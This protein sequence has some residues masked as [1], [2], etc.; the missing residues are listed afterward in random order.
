MTLNPEHAANVEPETW[1]S[2]TAANRERQE[3]QYFIEYEAALTQ[4]LTV[5]SATVSLAPLYLE[6]VLNTQ[7][8]I[9]NV[10]KRQD[11]TKRH[12]T[13]LLKRRRH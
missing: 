12:T 9:R 6:E 11:Y 10:L 13:K 1:M 5:W 7:S 4:R 2:K 8:Y 3:L